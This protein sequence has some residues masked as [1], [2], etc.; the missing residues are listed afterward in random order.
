MKIDKSILNVFSRKEDDESSK[1]EARENDITNV[2]QAKMSRP[3]S[4][5]DLFGNLLAEKLKKLPFEINL[6]AKNEID[7]MMFKY[8]IAKIR[9][10]PCYLSSVLLRFVH[11][12]LKGKTMSPENQ[13]CLSA[14]HR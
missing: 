14:Y 4:E 1:I 9:T 11:P 7:S 5:D 10:L 2:I 8:S 13:E 6:Q 3:M 12:T